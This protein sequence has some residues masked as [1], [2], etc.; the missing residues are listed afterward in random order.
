MKKFN[1]LSKRLTT[2]AISASMVATMPGMAN[3]AH[4]NIN[5]QEVE[6]V[7]EIDGVG[8]A[9]LEEAFENAESGNEIIL[10]SDAEVNKMILVDK[11]LTLNMGDGNLILF[12]EDA[13]DTSK[14]LGNI[15]IEGGSLTIDGYGY[16]EEE[17]P[18]YAPLMLKGA[19]DSNAEDYS[20]L[21]VG[22]DV[23][24]HGWSGIFV[25]QNGN[26]AY[27]VK[28]EM[29]G[30]ASSG[31]DGDSSGSAIYV[32]GSITE[33]EGN[34]PEIVIGENANLSSDDSTCLYLAGYAD[35]Y[36]YGNLNGCES[37]VEIRAGKLTIEDGAEISSTYVPTEEESN[38]NG[39]AIDGAAIAIAQHTT[40]LP[41][42]VSVN[43]GNIAGYTALYQAD[44]EE[45]ND[46][47]NI[48]IDVSGGSFEVIDD[49]DTIIYS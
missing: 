35:T 25:R 3:I 2:L 28:I 46:D 32:N 36:V 40:K 1:I 21:T 24:L 5:Q 22:D 42:E 8:Y 34:I 15:T 33:T 27:G 47:E 16:I 31:T 10:L 7:A 19:T 48:T 38:G 9:T 11:E 49:S 39:S 45:N 41:I 12:K 44:P 30:S 6:N 26:A 43:G 13:I 4:A 20:V 37:G 18:Y 14:K 17:N 23:S 29:N